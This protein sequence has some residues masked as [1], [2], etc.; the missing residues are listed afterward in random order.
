[1]MSLYGGVIATTGIYLEGLA[2]GLAQ[3]RCLAA[4][5]ATNAFFSLKLAATEAGKAGK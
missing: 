5:F 1:M 4:A 2:C 3:P